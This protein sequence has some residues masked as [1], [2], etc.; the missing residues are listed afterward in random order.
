[1]S[2]SLSLGDR[3]ESRQEEIHLSDYWSIIVK[4]RRLIAWSVGIAILLGIAVSLLSDPTYRA[5]VVL[6]VEREK[7][8]PFDISGQSAYAGYDPEFVPTQT[9]LMRS[10]EVAERT[11]NRLRLADNPEIVPPERKLFGSS[12]P[13]TGEQRVAR[14]AMNVQ[15]DVATTPIRGT[16]L[17]ELSF[18]A[19]TPKLAADVANALADAYI[20]WSLE[21]K[22]LVVGQASRFMGAQ[23]EQLKAELADREK[24][25]QAY[26][27]QEDIISI[28]PQ[29]NVTIQ[30][31]ESLNRDYAEAV[32]DRVAKEA[33]FYEIQNARPDTIADTLSSGLISQLRTD[34]AKLERDYAEKL[35]LYK[36]EWPAMLQLK[37]QIDKGR[38]NLA[39]V[40]QETVSKARDNA[41]SEYQTAQRREQSL[42]GVLAGQKNEAMNLNANAVE[43]NNLRTE[44]ETKRTLLDTLL[45]RQAET[46]VTSRLQGQRVSNIRVVDRALPPRFRFRPSYKRN[47]LL[48]L[49]FG[50][51]FGVGLAFLFEY[52]DRSLRTTEAVEKYLRLP[53]LG[54]IPAANTSGGYGYG[55]KKRSKLRKVGDDPAIELLP[56]TSPRA[57]VSEAYRAFRA[58]LLLSR[59]G[60]IRTIA[61]TSSAPGEGKTSTS[62]NLAVV[63]AQLGKKVLLV[64]A[65]LHKP[66]IHEVF[67]VSN[68]VGL[69]SILAEK[70]DPLMA[71]QPTKVKN[72]S[73]V[74]S[75][76]MSPNPSGLLSS[77]AMKQFLQTVA[78]NFDFVIIDTPP[79]SPV[80]DAILIGY[81]LDGVVLCVKGGTTPRDLVARTRDKL[82]RS[83][84]RILGVLINNLIEDEFG[85]GKYYSYYAASK[86]Y[87]DE[88]P[89]RTISAS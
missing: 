5:T 32:A 28:D 38:Q 68:R 34:Q 66:R 54:V 63:L 59:A 84:V 42:K 35:N 36:P 24:R 50:L 15:E 47:G 13:M 49:F 39:S 85:Y 1:M 56:E 20:D 67:R 73:L 23:I 19:S 89:T 78:E 61:V 21:S 72:L 64:D 65:D 8:S 26:A 10:R 18:V 71:I 4:Y 76:P 17:V 29:Q 37:A 45:K 11:V 74:P 87:G 31:L 51:G 82:A 69:V 27:R 3:S 12:E 40:I 79:V 88:A 7:S 25:L 83:N 57:T 77:D 52:M 86:A 41:R 9:R 46:E 80:A 75:G 30:K 48:S 16:N 53:A 43:Y 22:Y 44:V 70:T 33:R 58:A 62:V 6:N 81:Q 14:A 60:G 2:S 55:G